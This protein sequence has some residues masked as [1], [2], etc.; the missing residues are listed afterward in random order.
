M[1]KLSLSKTKV[2]LTASQKEALEALESGKNVFLTGEAGT[3]KS[4]LLSH[5]V[6][7]VKNDKTVLI[8]APTGK[9]SLNVG[10]V[11]LHRLFS[12][13]T[14][15]LSL[16]Q[17]PTITQTAEPLK[18]AD[19][20]IIDEVSMCRLDVFEK[21]MKTLKLANPDIQVVLVGDFLQLPPVLVNDEAKIYEELHGARVYAF[22]SVLW[23]EFDFVTKQLKEVVR[24]KDPE[25][26][27][28]LNL[29]RRGNADCI[30]YFNSLNSKRPKGAIEVCGSNKTA[31]KINE[32]ELD[33]IESFQ[34]TY[35]AEI[36]ILEEGFKLTNAEKPIDDTIKLKVGARVVLCA[37]ITD[38]NV[39]NGQMGTITRMDERGVFVDFDGKDEEV[40][41]C[42]YEW[43]INTYKT[44]T[45]K[46]TGR[47][48][49]SLVTIATFTQLPIKLG[50]AVTIHKS[51]GQTYEK[52]VVHPSCWER[53]QLYVA[54]SRVSSAKGLYLTNKIQE[55]YLI[56]DK[57]VL[58]FYN[59]EYVRP[60]P[61]KQE[62]EEDIVVEAPAPA[63]KPKEKQKTGR[64]R[65]FN[66]LDTKTVRLPADY[67]DFA[68][69][70]CDLLA[71]MEANE[72]YL[73]KILKNIKPT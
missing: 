9:A 59:G 10:G 47:K 72:K 35:R 63:E 14:D 33:K 69:K 12:L 43:A 41:I 16:A 51:Q 17:E 45:D 70:V 46:K 2:E 7:K 5:F 15:V 11:T 40:Y 57:T 6:A 19:I 54:L 36:E 38:K 66:G 62:Q 13:G 34:K 64:K 25:F 61:P 42:E 48:K 22:E 65:K 21:C 30:S 60:E 71:S 28:N 49:T 53:G 68:I 44:T 1:K 27:E 8:S 39:F 67:V 37:N 55:K 73:E 29:A 32:R 18:N 3:G 24:Q 50:F 58:D 31:N 26:I 56:A 52:A 4:F 23:E 20:L